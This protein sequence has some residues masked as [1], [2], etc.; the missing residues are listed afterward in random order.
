MHPL[1]SLLIAVLIFCIAA[2]GIL[3]IC[4]SFELPAPVKWVAGVI[5][6]LILLIWITDSF[7]GGVGVFPANRW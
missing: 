1:V 2:F 3:W 7:G 4:R 5:L 6:L